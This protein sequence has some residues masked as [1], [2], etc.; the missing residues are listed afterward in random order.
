MIYKDGVKATKIELLVDDNMMCNVHLSDGRVYS[1][2][3][4]KVNPSIKH[5]E[6]KLSAFSVLT[7]ARTL[8]QLRQEMEK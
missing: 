4:A 8:E 2:K 7:I 6:S 1:G 5:N 3:Q